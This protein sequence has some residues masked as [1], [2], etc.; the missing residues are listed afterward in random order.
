MQINT[1]EL[2]NFVDAKS[3][4]P[5]NLERIGQ[6]GPEIAAKAM[7]LTDSW[8]GV[9]FQLTQE[10]LTRIALALAFSQSTA[11]AIHQEIR[12][13]AYA[14]TLDN[15]SK[16]A[17]ATYHSL[18]VTFLALRNFTDFNRALT[19]FND[20]NIEWFL[21]THQDM[22]Q[23]IRESLPSHAARMN[24]K[25]E[26]ASTVLRSFGAEISADKL[27]ALASK[28][29]TSSVVDVEGR[30]GVTVEFIRS[31]TLTLAAALSSSTSN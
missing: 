24:F 15:A 30:R 25:P 14:T 31:T 16:A 7:E 9:M 29:G 18:D 12:K 8:A 22:F 1:S 4:K 19:S 20:D 10:E 26:T 11:E 5:N 2:G 13:L 23:R 21:D 6:R 17:V 3:V 27:Y 28:Y